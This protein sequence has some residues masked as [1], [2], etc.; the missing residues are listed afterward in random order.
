MNLIKEEVLITIAE[1]HPTDNRFKFNLKH[2]LSLKMRIGK[3]LKGSPLRI[4]FVSCI[5]FFHQ[6]KANFTLDLIPIT[7]EG[8]INIKMMIDSFSEGITSW[9]LTS[10]TLTTFIDGITSKC[11]G[12]DCVPLNAYTREV[13]FDLICTPFSVMLHFRTI[14]FFLTF[15]M[16]KSNTM[17]NIAKIHYMK[18]N[19]HWV[20][21]LL[22]I[23]F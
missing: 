15:S 20:T 19:L 14:H 9:F 12:K 11:I 17:L 7:R 3:W 4:L 18:M 2:F 1:L 16:C 22:Q 5:K 21:L 8:F 13:H 10:S 6:W 23:V